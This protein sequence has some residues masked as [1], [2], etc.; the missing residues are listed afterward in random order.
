[1]PPLLRQ[2]VTRHARTASLAALLPL[3]GSLAFTSPAKAAPPS[4]QAI[5]ATGI[6]TG[7]IP[8]P[9]CSN[10]V[11]AG[12]TFEIDFSNIFTANG[13]SLPLNKFYSLQIANL[14]TATANT[15]SFTN[16]EFLVSGS[17]GMTPFA[18]QAITIWDMNDGSYA[19]TTPSFPLAQG[20][21]GYLTSGNNNTFS[22]RQVSSQATFT[23]S[24]PNAPGWPNLGTAGFINTVAINL[25]TAGITD[26]TGAKIRGTYSGSTND[27]SAFS[28]GLALFDSDPATVLAAPNLI[29]GNA[30]NAVPGPLPIVGAGAAFGWSRRLRR[31]VKKGAAAASVA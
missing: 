21:S 3:M 2:A 6:V 16:V 17:F 29:Y 7:N 1:M 24:G 10:P 9:A 26:F 11:Q 12:N 15:L 8:S 19:G 13:G 4:C 20:L 14:N 31:R 30:F 23:L 28:A 25:Q 22:G 18:N 27:I 5:N